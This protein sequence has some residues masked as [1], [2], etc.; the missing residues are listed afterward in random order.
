MGRVIT[1]IFDRVSR[2]R[3]YN[4]ATQTLTLPGAL[5]T[6]DPGDG[7]RRIEI[8]PNSTPMAPEV[9][10]YWLEVT[11]TGKVYFNVDGVR[12]EI[13][14]AQ[15]ALLVS[16]NFLRADENPLAGNWATAPG[17][18]ALKIAN[19]ELLPTSVGQYNGAIW[20]GDPFDA[21]QFAEI[22]I[23]GMSYQGPVVRGSGSSSLTG[24]FF[25][26]SGVDPAVGALCA[27]ANGSQQVIGTTTSL[28]QAAGARYQLRAI[29]TTI[30][31]HEW[32]GTEW[33]QKISVTDLAATSG[34]AG[35]IQ[36]DT[37]TGNSVSAWSAGDL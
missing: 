7:N 33:V 4:P 20:T 21:D 10:K 12:R 34:S 17:L 22:T 36:Y 19:N 27:Y 1:K 14:L 30:S 18:Q 3:D 2:L 25:Q 29:G 5:V 9:G 24:Y 23:A 6:G 13:T 16:D 15:A 26:L 31:A 11:S 28:A 37:T 35:M 32:S 8:L